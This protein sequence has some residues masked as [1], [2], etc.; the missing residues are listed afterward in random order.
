ME[1]PKKSSWRNKLKSFFGRGKEEEKMRMTSFVEPKRQV[2]E[3]MLDSYVEVGEE[4]ET[5]EVMKKRQK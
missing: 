3:D 5:F 1:E 2:E 4:V